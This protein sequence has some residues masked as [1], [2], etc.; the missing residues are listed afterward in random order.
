MRSKK[1]EKKDK[2]LEERNE[3]RAFSA[4]VSPTN[5][6]KLHFRREEEEES[7]T[8]KPL[9]GSYTPTP[10]LIMKKTYKKSKAPPTFSFSPGSPKHGS[11]RLG[12]SVLHSV[13]LSMSELWYMKKSIIKIREQ[14]HRINLPPAKK[15]KTLLLDLDNTLIYAIEEAKHTSPKSPKYN[16]PMYR[17]EIHNISYVIRPGLMSF[18]KEMRKYYEMWIYTAGET[19]YAKDILN[20]ID[21]KH[22]YLLGALTRKNCIQL[23]ATDKTTEESRLFTIKSVK[24]IQ[25]RKSKD[26]V[27]IDDTL[28]VWAEDL[29]NILPIPSFKG[30]QKDSEL[31][32]RVDLLRTLALADD[33]S[34]LLN[35]IFGIN[36]LVHQYIELEKQ[37]LV[38]T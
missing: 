21:P 36:K 10:K 32:L 4:P 19:E 13:Q 6:I 24:L 34:Q 33:V 2:F 18:L 16:I 17:T 14:A 26:I 5:E 3:F 28:H 11:G 7:K 38:I 20:S 27:V 29:S 30:S 37:N 8:T 35:K 22:E 23:T 1:D 31:Q 12:A 9:Y 15:K 25:N